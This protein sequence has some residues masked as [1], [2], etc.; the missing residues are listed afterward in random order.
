MDGS[1]SSRPGMLSVRVR[2]A[3]TGNVTQLK[4]FMLV[5]LEH[6][7]P[8]L[9]PGPQA[10]RSGGSLLIDTGP[11]EGAFRFDRITV[12]IVLDAMPAHHAAYGTDRRSSVPL[13]PGDGW[14]LPA[15]L[16]AWCR[17]ERANV[18]N[19][20]VDA[21]LMREAGLAADFDPIA[22]DIDPL[23]AQLALNLH[24]GNA[25]DQLYRESLSSA[26]AAQL[27][28]TLNGDSRPAVAPDPRVRRAMEYVEAHLSDVISLE[29]L[30]GA[31]AMSRFHFSDVFRRTTGLSPYAYVIARRMEQAKLLL[32]TTRLPVA[33]VAWRLGYANPAK[34]A[35]QFRRS[36]GMNPSAWRSR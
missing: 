13:L 20:A 2:L 24:L 21:D 14:I 6:L 33:D 3:G 36:T 11:G 29:A 28:K 9:R 35:R 23:L 22:G 34:F 27:V 16:D 31:A 1:K 5:G 4:A 25:G 26:F 30:A 8:R 7:R 32:A 12:G 15:G 19:V 17:W 18:L 10:W